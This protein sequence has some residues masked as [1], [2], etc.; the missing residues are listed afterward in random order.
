MELLFFQAGYCGTR[1]LLHWQRQRERVQFCCLLRLDRNKVFMGCMV[2]LSIYLSIAWYFLLFLISFSWSDDEKVC[3][4]FRLNLSYINI[5]YSN[6]YLPCETSKNIILAHMIFIYFTS[7]NFYCLC[8][9]RLE[10]LW[11]KCK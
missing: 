3:V 10:I 7:K 1:V 11:F 6:T 5:L 4:K 8:G 2:S 9:Y